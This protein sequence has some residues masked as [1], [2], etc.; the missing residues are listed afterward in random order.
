MV[1]HD[2]WEYDQFEIIKVSNPKLF[3]MEKTHATPHTSKLEKR[4]DGRSA[5]AFS[6]LN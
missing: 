2:I 1:G 5:V 3:E 4:D 6:T